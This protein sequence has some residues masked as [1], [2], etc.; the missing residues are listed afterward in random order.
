MEVMEAN[1]RL[2]E[3]ETDEEVRSVAE[4]NRGLLLVFKQIF[5]F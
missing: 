2:G 5:I 3:A 1:E 4:E